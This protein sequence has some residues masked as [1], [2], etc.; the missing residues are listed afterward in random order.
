MR[1]QVVPNRKFQLG[2]LPRDPLEQG[3]EEF[4]SPTHLK[5]QVKRPVCEREREL[6]PKVERAQLLQLL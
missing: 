5:E 4:G 3:L 6:L 2:H 1:A